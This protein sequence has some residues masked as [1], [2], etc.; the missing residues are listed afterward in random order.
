M[1]T[2]IYV[3]ST[4]FILVILTRMSRIKTGKQIHVKPI[5]DVVSIILYTVLTF[6]GLTLV[7]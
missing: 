1:N 3:V 2:F 6:W 4:V 7:L 5:H